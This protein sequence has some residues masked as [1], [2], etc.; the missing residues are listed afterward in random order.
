MA[1]T[2]HDR[3][4]FTWPEWAAALA[5]E[6]K[7]AQAAGDPDIG[8]TYSSALARHAGRA[9]REQGRRV[10]G[11][12]APLSRRL[13]PRT[14]R[15]RWRTD[16]VGTRIHS[17]ERHAPPHNC[18]CSEAGNQSRSRSHS[19]C[20][21]SSL[22]DD[23]VM[24]R[25][26]HY[27]PAQLPP[28]LRPQTARRTLTAA[29]APIML[30]AAF[31]ETQVRDC[32]RMRS[33]MRP[34]RRGRAPASHVAALS[35][36]I[37]GRCSSN[38]GRCRA[39]AWPAWRG[40]CRRGNRD[41]R[42][43]RSRTCRRRC[44]DAAPV[45]QRRGKG[46]EHQIAAGTNVFGKPSAPMAIAT[47]RV[48]A[49]S[50]YAAS[51]G[52]DSVWGSPSSARPIR[53]QALMPSN[54]RSRQSS[55]TRGVAVLEPQRFHARE[56]A[57]RPGEA[58][59]R[60]L[61]AGKQH[62]RGFGMKMR[63]SWPRFSIARRF[64]QSVEIGLFRM[65]PRWERWP[66]FWH[67]ALEPRRLPRNDPFPRHFPPDRDH[68][69]AAH[70]GDRL[71]WDLE[72][73]FATIAPY[74]IEEAHEVVDAID[75]GD[76]DDLR[77]ELGDLLLQV[78]FH[79][80]DGRGTERFRL[81]RRRRGHHAQDDPASSAR[82]R[83]QGR[84]SASSHVKEVWDRIKAEEK[85][86]RAARRPRR[87]P[88]QIAAVG[89]QGR[90]AGADARME[91]QRKASTVGFDWND[92]ARGPARSA[93]KPTRSRP[94]LDRNDKQEMV[95]ETGDLMFALVNLARHVDADPEAALREP[96][97]NSTRLRSSNGRWRRRAHAG[98]GVAGGDGRAV[99]RGEGRGEPVSETAGRS[100]IDRYR[101]AR[102]PEK[103]A[104]RFGDRVD[105]FK[106]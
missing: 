62:Q 3:G 2:L 48:S 64:S 50:G 46:Q 76:L 78:V 74:T 13:G 84:Q 71:P 103:G 16:R 72:Q 8:E 42:N 87:R 79:A 68:G 44:R 83:R 6:I 39:R 36:H 14:D 57:Q 9:G 53:A 80:A 20:I 97:R 51:V 47:S 75:R 88:A 99:E 10:D 40:W 65:P 98:A 7:R 77:E 22:A 18:H 32:S 52:I 94:A 35:I 89:R 56:A 92:P 100:D 11:H 106:P 25:R 24:T 38:R 37:S 41:S 12:A 82:L 19:V 30:R 96:T 5:F 15:P 81:R 102:S 90:P 70:A 29:I 59:G 60:N 31:A 73:N 55:S 23:G 85:A 45:G 54:S 61:A 49:V 104:R 66:D 93:R 69:G 33:T 86:E 43:S 91:L 26:T 101:S 63:H 58:G 28:P 27:L 95:E 67:K 21:W 4:V 105:H 17:V 34:R 1:L